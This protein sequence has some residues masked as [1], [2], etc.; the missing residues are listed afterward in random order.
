MRADWLE[1]G[2]VARFHA[3]AEQREHLLSLLQDAEPADAEAQRAGIGDRLRRLGR[4]YADLQ[5]DDAAYDGERRALE[6]EPDRLTVPTEQAALAVETFDV[7][8][9]A[10]SRATPQE[11][12]AL[13][14]TL[15]EAV[16]VDM[17]TTTIA[18]VVVQP[19]FCPWLR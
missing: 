18:G 4:L 12:R 19:A 5:I 6:A 10:W 7:P 17:A 14:L 16:Y 3:P 13:A 8:Q 1:A 2:I 15:F 11:K 9:T